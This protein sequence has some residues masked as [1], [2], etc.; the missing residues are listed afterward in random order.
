MNISAKHAVWFFI[1]AGTAYGQD[2]PTENQSP[3]NNLV[4]EE[5]VVT[6]R[7]RE[8]NP[9][10]ISESLTVFGA[11][12]ID[13]ND[14]DNLTDI[15]NLVPNMYM[16]VRADGLPNVSIRGVG[17]FGN[18]QGVGFYLDDVQ[19]YADATAS[20]GDIERIEVLKGP[21]GTLYGGSNIGGAVKYVTNKPDPSGFSGNAQVGFGED[22][23]YKAS[24]VI[25]APL[26]ADWAVRLFAQT[27]NDDSFLVNP[28]SPR[29]NGN[30]N[31]NDPDVGHREQTAFRLSLAG[32][33]TDRFSLFASL[34]YN[35]LDAPNNYWVR[36]LSPDFEYPATL[37]TTFN[38]RLERDTVA[39]TVELT[40]DFENVAFT[41]LTSYADTDANRSV[42]I[43]LTQE[44]IIDSVH[45]QKSETF[46]QE[47]RLTSTDSSPLQWLTGLY[48]VDYSREEESQLLAGAAFFNPTPTLEEELAPP[49]EIPFRNYNRYRDQT[50]AF[51][52]LS[53]RTD[54]YEYAVGARADRW[55][56]YRFN[57]DTGL[58][59][60]QSDTEFLFRGSVTRF[61]E[62]DQS[63]VY[64]LI[65]QGFEP[66]DFN[67]TSFTNADTLLGY[68][69]EK[70]TNFEAGYKGRLAD[71]RAV[72]TF[73]AFLVEYEDRQF[74]LQTED[75]N[76]EGIVEGIINAGD[77]QQWGFE[78]D[79]EWRLDELWTL[80]AGIGY[81]NAEWKSG[82]VSPIN[83]AD[84]SGRTPPQS[85]EWS[86]IAALSY[87]QNLGGDREIFGR[88]QVQ[89]KGE[90]TTNSQFLDVPGDDFPI[91]TNPSYTVVDL[92]VGYL[93]SDWELNFLVE[94]LFDEDYYVDAQEFP[95]FASAFIPQSTII[96]GTVE[97]KRR[98]SAML[99]YNFGD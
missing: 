18:T 42:D 81:L 9:L 23:Y 3:G 58:P 51:G 54:K 32:A 88:L 5:I 62:D 4:I 29:V 2:A 21:Q 85:P 8:E 44:Y 16:A 93:W 33:F 75:P 72:L 48:Y 41:S 80:Q 89:Y 59:G 19:V 15:A 46:S 84:L 43:D 55:T 94:N 37:D 90:V 31:N 10:E 34:R 68:G 56:S 45:D 96:I 57:D 64:G 61:L 65:S 28:N 39:A 40:Y 92:N 66:G 79:I 30:R 82:T 71:D 6:A 26:S 49:F 7:K 73:A 38:P 24:A 74:E 87:N 25:N 12:F 76:G 52:N 77:S 50:A 14:I 1:W 70:A 17:A 27:E 11:D 63:M 98:I 95:N 20:F 35:D 60:K 78:A 13:N 86:G 22:N 97:Q 53:Y 99:T 83:D 47:F 91:W 69:P 36:E 67:L